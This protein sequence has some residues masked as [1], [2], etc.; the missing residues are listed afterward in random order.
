MLVDMPVLLFE[1]NGE[2]HSFIHFA[3]PP[4]F[5]GRSIPVLKKNEAK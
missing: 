3:W 5:E 4:R 2:P 1:R